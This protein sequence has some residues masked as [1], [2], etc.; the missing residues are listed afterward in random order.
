MHTKKYK[1]IINKKAIAKEDNMS[2]LDLEKDF[3][4]LDTRELVREAIEEAFY[5]D[6]S[7]NTGSIEN[8]CDEEA[9]KYYIALSNKEE[10]GIKKQQ[11][12][13]EKFVESEWQ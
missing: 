9:K 11:E 13:L 4:E 6:D 2:S 8:H 12:K 3:D 1:L 5:G 10:W 7:I